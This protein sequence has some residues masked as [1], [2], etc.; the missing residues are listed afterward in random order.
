MRLREYAQNFGV[1]RDQ[2]HAVAVS[3]GSDSMAMLHLLAEQEWKLEAV[4]VD[5]GLRPESGSEAAFV[6][7]RCRYLGVSHTTLSWDRA[8]TGGN[9]QDQARRARY[10]LMRDWAVSRGIGH[11]SLGHTMDDQAETFLMRI[12]RGSGL[13]GICGM[14]SRKHEPHVTW[15]RPF[16]KARRVELRAYLER[17][18][19]PWI[20]DPSNED[21][22][23]DRVKARRALEHLAPLGIDPPKIWALTAKLKAVRSDLDLRG[24][25]A[26]VSAGAEVAGDVIL[27][28]P[29]FRQA[30]GGGEVLRRT[31][32]AALRWMSGADY[33]PRGE[34]LL[35]LLTAARKGETRTLHGCLVT[36]GKEM[37][38]SREYNAVKDLA[39][40]TESL[41]D[42]RW[43]LDGPHASDLE[44]RALG[45]A[46][47]DTPWRETNLPRRSLVAT[48]AVW[49]GDTLVAAPV[50]GLPN[51]WTAQ[52]TG[53]G[54]F[55]DFLLCR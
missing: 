25:D 9:L 34:A 28:F 43:R 6:E 21:L 3:G 42:G 50:A 2:V 31:V 18:N 23:Y 1:K 15:V 52:A 11:I 54:N 10:G 17:R 37:R 27:R 44:I 14:D 4:T 24:R 35:E 5:H 20:D 8:E 33:P 7:E 40:P 45:D 22:G 48:P 51:G 55:A 39:C 36:S 29:D 53:R 47:S 12:A 46:V 19:V 13:D 49:R 16:L 32:I 30:A 26:F 41:W 38:F